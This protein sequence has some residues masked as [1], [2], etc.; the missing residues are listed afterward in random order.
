MNKRAHYD[1][2]N[3]VNNSDRGSSAADLPAG[4]VWAR[5]D[6]CVDV[7]DSKRVP[8]NAT[9]REQRIDGEPESALIPYYGATGKVGWIDDYLFDEELLLLGED[10]A[11][12]LE[13]NKN[14]A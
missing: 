3:R 4:W 14:K 2:S 7:L 13:S 6:K 5:L 9:E 8:I 10:G 1:D 11:P 12:F